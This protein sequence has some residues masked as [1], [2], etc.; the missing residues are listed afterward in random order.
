[1]KHTAVALMLAT[2]LLAATPAL[3]KPKPSAPPTYLPSVLMPY[4]AYAPIFVAPV[5]EPKK[6]T[7][8]SNPYTPDPTWSGGKELIC[9][10]PRAPTR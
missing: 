1:V 2:L 6:N 7:G 9:G 5:P 10:L 3:A 8:A 4:N